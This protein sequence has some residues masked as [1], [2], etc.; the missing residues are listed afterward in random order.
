MRRLVILTLLVGGLVAASSAAAQASGPPAGR[1]AF[2]RACD[3]R[4]IDADGRGERQSLCSPRDTPP[5]WSPEGGG[6][7]ILAGDA[8][9][10]ASRPAGA[11]STPRPLVVLI[12]GLGS[13]IPSREDDP[14]GGD[15]TFVKRRLEAA[16]YDVYPAATRPNAPPGADPEFIDSQSG[17]WRESAARLDRQL[18]DEGYG[19]RS[20]ILV[21]HSMG[22]LIARVYAQIWRDLGSGCGPLGIVQLGTPNKGSEAAHLAVGPFDS[23][24]AGKLADPIRMAAF[25]DEFQNDQGLPIYRL[26]GAYFPTSAYALSRRRADLGLIW[27]AVYALYGARDN[28]SVVTVDSVRGGPTRG[29]RGCATFKAVHADSAW[30]SSFRDAAGC[31]LPR[32]SGKKGAAAIDEKIMRRI[33]ADV[34]AVA[35]SGGASSAPRREKRIPLAHRIW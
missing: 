18:A 17:D 29:W 6:S 23:D 2:V 5:S 9:E 13:S 33:S 14:R 27:N 34:R 20:V 32:R 26:A 1:I 25:N 11:P 24:A 31:V 21:G 7:R 15:W 35:K 10:P 19:G 8:D 30:L 3:I 16:G 4:V 12:G 22:G 28:D